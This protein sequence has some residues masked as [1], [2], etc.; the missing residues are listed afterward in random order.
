[1]KVRGKRE[2]PQLFDLKADPGETTDLAAKHP[3]RVKALLAAY[4][5][6]AKDLPQPLWM[7]TRDNAP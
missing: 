4:E 1:M 5:G 2:K 6:W 7:N 3:E